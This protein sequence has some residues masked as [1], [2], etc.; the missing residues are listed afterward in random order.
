MGQAGNSSP[1]VWYK[2]IS[3]NK[4]SSEI[5]FQL[6][7]KD[8]NPHKRNQ[9]PMCYRYTTGQFFI[10]LQRCDFFLFL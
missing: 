5:S 10:A 4:M 7:W 2:K 1:N 9:N 8:S 6:S 3:E